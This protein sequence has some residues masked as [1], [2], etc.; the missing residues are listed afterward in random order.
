MGSNPARN[1]DAA[2][3]F[4]ERQNPAAFFCFGLKMC[5]VRSFGRIIFRKKQEDRDFPEHFRLSV[6]QNRNIRNMSIGYICNYEMC[7]NKIYTY[8]KYMAFVLLM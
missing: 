6:L 2:G 5:I 3:D 1:G 8:K 4:V 7:H